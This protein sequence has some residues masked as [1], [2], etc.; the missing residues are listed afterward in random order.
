M[1]TSF[2]RNAALDLLIK[3]K[4]NYSRV[5]EELGY[6][7]KETLRKWYKIY[8]QSNGV[9]HTNEEVGGYNDVQ[10]KL[11]EKLSGKRSFRIRLSK[12]APASCET[13]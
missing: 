9:G 8:C 11:I 12:N 4:F 7:A 6:P 2:Q 5:I 10:R 13:R 3:Y 1:Y